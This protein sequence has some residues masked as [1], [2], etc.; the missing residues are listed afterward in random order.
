MAVFYCH[1]KALLASVSSVGSICFSLVSRKL[2]ILLASGLSVFS[3][4]HL[5]F[6]WHLGFLWFSLLAPIR[7]CHD[8]ESF[9]LLASFSSVASRILIYWHQDVTAITSK[10]FNFYWHLFL[11]WHQFGNSRA[12]RIF[13]WYH[14]V[15]VMNQK[16]PKCYWNLFLHC[17][18]LLFHWQ[19]QFF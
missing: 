14:D 16:F 3:W 4:H 11:Q 6:Q 7:Y 5:V 12:S 1:D 19:S 2:F 15:I 13:N 8:I 10:G 9:H 18:W 17:H